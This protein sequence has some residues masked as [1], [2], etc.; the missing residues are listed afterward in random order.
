MEVPTSV[1]ED[2]KRGDPDAFAELVRLTHKQVYSLAL[3]LLGNPED[4][5]EATQETYMKVLRGIKGF[6]GEAKFSTWL[7]RVTSSA[8]VTELRKRRRRG[9]EVPL[10][11]LDGEEPS[12][13]RDPAQIAEQHDLGRSL[14]AA[15]KGLPEG[16]RTVVVLRDVYD[17]P[18]AEVGRQMGIS[19]GAA[20]VRLFRARQR[21]KEIIE[22]RA[23]DRPERKAGSQ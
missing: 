15:I 12:D 14:E 4:A 21:L 17:L 8:A 3:R 19:E 7:Y 11:T 16:Y 2:C 20:K 1:V 23:G 13:P 22:K 9:R 5:A 18:L 6:R 10:E